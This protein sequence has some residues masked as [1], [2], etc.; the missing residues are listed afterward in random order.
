MTSSNLSTETVAEY[1]VY[2]KPAC[3]QCDE[4]KAY[5]DRKGI[6]FHE[7]DVTTNEGAFEYITEELGYSQVPVVVNNADDEDHWAGLR[8]DKL[9]QAAMHHKAA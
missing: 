2:T 5:F 4:T 9:V 7:V 8:R 1:T 3:S 6:A